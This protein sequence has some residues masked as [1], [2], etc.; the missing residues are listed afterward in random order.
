MLSDNGLEFLI[1]SL[2]TPLILTALTLLVF[3]LVLV[4]VLVIRGGGGSGGREPRERRPPSTGPLSA[5][6]RTE[7]LSV[8]RQ[9]TAW[10]SDYSESV[11]RYQQRLETLAAEIQ[12]E[13]GAAAPPQATLQE[14]VARVSGLFQEM[15]R[16]NAQMQQQLAAAENQLHWQIDQIESSL[17]EARTDGLTQLANRRSFDAALDQLVAARQGS[18]SA[19]VLMMIDIDHFKKINDAHGHPSGDRVLQHVASTL[20]TT[21]PDAHLAA[22]Y[23][24]EEFA[25]ILPGPLDHAV[26]RAECLRAAVSG[27]R[28]DIGEQRVQVTLSCGLSELGEGATTETWVRQ[29]DQALYAAKHQGRNHVGYHDGRQSVLLATAGPMAPNH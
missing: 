18:A 12:R 9:L 19:A 27:Q 3:A 21:F 5:A 1:S 17:T 22:R 6:E 15:M 29:A 7:L 23:G 14:N 2:T 8:L 10:S 16:D 26:Q 24:G 28:I 11:A 25:V 20:R 13:A 4:N